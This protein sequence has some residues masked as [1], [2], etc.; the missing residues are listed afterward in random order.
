M[1]YFCS[2][3]KLP[4]NRKAIEIKYCG[5]MKNI[6]CINEFKKKTTVTI[7]KSIIKLTASNVIY[8]DILIINFRPFFYR[9]F[10]CS[11]YLIY[12]LVL[13]N[14]EIIIRIDSGEVR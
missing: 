13:R 6:R 1:R 5:V 4:V 2:V 10:H 9:L 7:G 3:K 14:A 11:T 8:F 12:L